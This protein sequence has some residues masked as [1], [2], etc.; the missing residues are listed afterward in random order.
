[1]SPGIGAPSVDC[2]DLLG[3]A[4]LL[5]LEAGVLRERANSTNEIVVRDQYLKLADR[6]AMLAAALETC[7]FEQLSQARPL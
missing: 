1:M 5:R 7:S 6:W 2:S 4:A 3:R